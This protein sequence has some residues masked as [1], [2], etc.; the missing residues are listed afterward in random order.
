[1]SWGFFFSSGCRQTGQS[2]WHIFT[3][4]FS[5]ANGLITKESLVG[6]GS[7]VCPNKHT[8]KSVPQLTKLETVPD[9]SAYPL[10]KEKRSSTD[11][12]GNNEGTREF[13]GRRGVFLR[14]I[15]GEYRAKTLSRR[16]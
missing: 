2:L 16:W 5:L 3:P 7:L 14:E 10:A 9:L 13:Y 6:V 8:S 15:C 12:P 1:M 11:F 4:A